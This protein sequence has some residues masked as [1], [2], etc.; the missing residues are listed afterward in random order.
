MTKRKM[1]DGDFGGF[2]GGK[3]TRANFSEF[4]GWVATDRAGVGVDTGYVPPVDKPGFEY[5]TMKLVRGKIHAFG[6]PLKQKQQ[7][8]CVTRVSQTEPE[9]I[10]HVDSSLYSIRQRLDDKSFMPKRVIVSCGIR[11]ETWGSTFVHF[12]PS[13]Q[14][15]VGHDKLTGDFRLEGRRIRRKAK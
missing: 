2:A 12:D 13:Y 3:R 15:W 6:K 9:T 5:D 4:G 8:E 14:E 11:H 10:T 7:I 1:R